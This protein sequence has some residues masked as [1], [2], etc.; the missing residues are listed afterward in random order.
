MQYFVELRLRLFTIVEGWVDCGDPSEA[1]SVPLV[2]H[3]LMV[4]DETLVLFQDALNC[5]NRPDLAQADVGEDAMDNEESCRTAVVL[6]KRFLVE[7]KLLGVNL[8]I[9]PRQRTDSFNMLVF[10]V[11]DE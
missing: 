9:C 1:R 2:F 10:V 3:P 5:V 7:L 8:W 4:R 11:D 6:T